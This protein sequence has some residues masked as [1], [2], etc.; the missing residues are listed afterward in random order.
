MWELLSK[1]CSFGREAAGGRAG[2][3]IELCCSSP[4]AIHQPGAH[5]AASALEFQGPEFQVSMVCPWL[6]FSFSPSPPSVVSSR[7]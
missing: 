7:R 5:G 4:A 1:R 6:L 3:M 2:A